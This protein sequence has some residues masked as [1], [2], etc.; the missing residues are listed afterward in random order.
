VYK[1]E[2]RARLRQVLWLVL[3]LSRISAL[4]ELEGF[5]NTVEKPPTKQ[6]A[7]ALAGRALCSLTRVYLQPE[8]A[9]QHSADAQH[10]ICAAF[11]VL[12]N[13]NAITAINKATFSVFIIFS[14]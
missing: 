10:D 2:N 6:K 14:F 5:E 11:T 7:R 12:A 1:Y 3:R 13:P 9:A 8:H 4:I